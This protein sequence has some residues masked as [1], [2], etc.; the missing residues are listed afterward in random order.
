MTPILGIISSGATGSKQSS[1]ESIATSTATGGETSL[2]FTS[3]PGTYKSLQIRGIGRDTY[4][5]ATT[6]LDLYM[7]FNSDTTAANYVYHTL[8]GNGASA[9]ATATTS[10][11]GAYIQRAIMATGSGPNT[12]TYGASIIDIIDYASTSKYKTV[13]NID[14]VDFNTSSTN[15]RFTLGS[16]L[17]LSTSAITR[18]D[19]KTTGTAFAAGTTYALYGI[20]GA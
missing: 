6:T 19:L 1:Y 16:S 18:I 15:Y 5:A 9:A 10:S 2:S 7:Q 13:K 14:G 17:W 12:T 4:T 8:Y 3:I 11:G 20:K